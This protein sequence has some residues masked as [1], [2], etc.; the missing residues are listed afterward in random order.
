MLPFGSHQAPLYR[1]LGLSVHLCTEYRGPLAEIGFG[2]QQQS[3]GCQ[4][5]DETPLSTA[6]SSRRFVSVFGGA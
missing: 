3:Y 5:S 2:L 6:E 4:L 1:V